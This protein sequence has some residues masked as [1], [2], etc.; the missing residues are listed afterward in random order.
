MD[1]W[2]WFTGYFHS[3]GGIQ[4]DCPKP[5]HSETN[6]E[7]GLP[8]IGGIGGGRIAARKSR[9]IAHSIEWFRNRQRQTHQSS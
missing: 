1:I 8:M 3:D 5:T 9:N 4:N 7:T 6:P 2:S